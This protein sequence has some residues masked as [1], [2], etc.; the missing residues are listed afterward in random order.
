[1]STGLTLP[2]VVGG[3][4]HRIRGCNLLAPRKKTVRR[5]ATANLRPHG[6]AHA[7]IRNRHAKAIDADQVD[8]LVGTD[9]GRLRPDNFLQLVGADRAIRRS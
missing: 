6:T 2:R 7:L 3:G 9:G 5:G 4:R 1:M 8:D